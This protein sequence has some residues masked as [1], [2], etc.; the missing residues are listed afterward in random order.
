MTKEAHSGCIKTRNKKEEKEKKRKR[1]SHFN[2]LIP[3]AL[4]TICGFL[5]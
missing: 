4:L 3:V 1:D 5:V 2:E